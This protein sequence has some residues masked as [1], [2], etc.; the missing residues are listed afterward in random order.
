[1]MKLN[2]LIASILAVFIYIIF[3]MNYWKENRSLFWDKS[4]YYVYLPATFL[5]NDIGH[6]SF[7]D[8]MNPKYRFTG[9][10]NYYSI[11]EQSTGKKLNKY[12]VGVS[13]FELPFFAVGHFITVLTK[14]FPA[15]GYSSYYMLL[16]SISSAVWSALGLL[17]LGLFLKR[18]FKDSI[19]YIV[20]LLLAFGT[21]LYVYSSFETGMSHP[22]S[23]FLVAS[24]LNVTDKWYQTKRN[25]WVLL[26]GLILGLIFIVRP[27]NVICLLIPL[28]WQ[29]E[30]ENIRNRFL[31]FK[32]NDKGI[33]LAMITGLSIAFLQLFYWKYVT[34][35]WLKYSYQGERFDFLN[36]HIWDGLFSYRK[37]WFVYTPLA[38]VAAIGFF[39]LKKY[40]AKILPLTVIMLVAVYVIFS[41]ATWF[42][43]GS[44]GCRAL[45]E[46]LPVMS[47]PLA[48]LITNM[49]AKGRLSKIVISTVL[50]LVL[51]LNIW[52]TYQFTQCVI[53][54]DH[55]NRAYY[56]KVFFK[57]KAM[58]EDEVL[59]HQ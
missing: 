5:Y 11:F 8:S 27:I 22:Y 3:N 44:F 24:L 33:L 36:P 19:V 28:L 9:K 26:L 18:Y 35:N 52:Q 43:G 40:S 41:W 54:W 48:A 51:V 49:F 1:M 32:H 53:P 25:K 47:F 10:E 12:S 50:V 2:L 45:I 20:L 56:W 46:Y 38:F 39:F 29:T 23:F 4:G 34:G 15:D 30:N 57:L 42:Y 21:N 16:V 58:P 17:V 7:L 59:L 6:L 37:G 14:E 31:F 13:L 55:N